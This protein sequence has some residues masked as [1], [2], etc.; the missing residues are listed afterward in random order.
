MV[1]RP[2]QPDRL[3][4]SGNQLSGEIP[5]ELGNLANLTWLLLS[6]NQLSGCVPSSLQNQLNSAESYLGGLPF[7]RGSE[8]STATPPQTQVSSDRETLVALY[9]ATD[10]PNWKNSTNWLSNAPLD[11]WQG[12]SADSTGRVFG[13]KLEGNRLSGEIPL[14]L[15][16]LAN[17]ESLG[18]E[19]NRLSGKIPP[20]LGNLANL[21]W[22]GLGGNRLSGEIPPELGDLASLR[23]LRLY[24]NPLTGGIPPE[25]G[26]L[27]NLQ[28][29]IL[30][31]NPLTGEIPS[32]LGNLASLTWLDLRGNQLSGAIPPQLGNLANLE[33]L[34]FGGNQL[35]GPIPA[36]LGS[37]VNLESLSLERNRLTGEIPP[38]LSNLTNLEYLGFSRN[39]LTGEIPEGLGDLASLTALRLDGNRLTGCVPSS[40][41]NQLDQ[42]DPYLGRLPFCRGSDASTATPRP[43]PVSSDR[44]VLVT[45]YH[46]ADGANWRN[47]TNWL[48]DA[49]LNEWHH[50]SVDSKGRVTRLDLKDNQLTGKIP[51]E[52]GN[53]VSLELLELGVNQL[54]GKIPPELGNLANL[55][56]LFLTFNQLTGEIPPELGNLANLESLDLSGNQ[57]RGCVPSSLQNQLSS[58]NLGGLSFC[59]GSDASTATPRPMP[60][61]S[62]REVLVTLYHAADGANWRNS[63]NWLSD[64]PLNEWHH[65]SVDSKGRV[66]RLDLKDNQLTGEI[67]PEL[68][69]LAN[70]EFLD[71]RRES[72]ERGD[73]VGTEQSRRP[74]SAVPQP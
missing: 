74:D 31:S 22:L 3:V 2:R 15:G 48:S 29:L 45:L 47:S 55:T 11:E 62:D 57:L 46:A 23:W 73:T 50:V 60:V 30:S 24:G 14:E 42:L 65:V 17:L 72:V 38:A 54:S 44:E 34:A 71:S 64:A 39:L 66:T 56:V 43:M 59:R 63:T 27:A 58:T 25:L 37:L 28:S 36:E 40:L 7:C 21:T 16:D 20:E 8:A 41:E 1:R 19:G 70:L 69:N 49:P 12:V 32:E 18:L 51:P 68:G 35:T 33:F 53:L 52:L 10:G 6:E 67:P 5:P 13:L 4:L 9:H 26:N 61:S